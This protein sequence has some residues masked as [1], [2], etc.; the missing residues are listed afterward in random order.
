MGW[1]ERLRPSKE[2]AVTT[3]YTQ[4]NDS[5]PNA[6]SE[7]QPSV[8]Y[9]GE[10]TFNRVKGGN[11]SGAAYQEAAGAPVESNSPLGYHVGW[12]TIIFLN[13]NQMIGTGIFS[14]PGSILNATGS[15]GLALIYW[16]IGAIMA[17]A[18][19]GTYLELASYFPNRSGSQVVYL[20][21]AYPRPKYF[22]PIA[23]AVQSVIL[24]FSSSNAVVLSRY[25]WRIAGKTPTDWE[26]K[27]VAIAA[28]TA[29]VICV[30]V[31]NRY[32]LWTVNVLGAFKVATLIFIS[33]TGFVVL[34]GGV[35]RV[36]QP[37]A[38]FR[39]AFQGTTNNGNDLSTALV[40]IAF[41]YSGYQNAFNVVNEIK[42]PVRTIKKHGLISVAIVSVLY[43]LCNIAYFSAVDKEAFA[44]SKEIAA[45]VFFTQVFGSGAAETVL[46]VLVLLSAYGNLLAVLIGQS[47]MIREIGRQGVL[48][49]TNFWVSTKPFGTPIGPYALKW[50]MTFI[51][52][53]APPAGDAFTFVV[54]LQTYPDSMFVFAMAIG[55]FILRRRRKK[56][57]I[58]RSQFQVWD[59]LL[60]FF[61]LIQV[62]I[63]VMP[64]W[65]PKGG[66]YAGDVS[67]WYATYCVV[68]IGIV[69]LCALY[70]VAWMYVLPKWLGYRI[71]AETVTAENETTATHRLVK[72]PLA[73]V[74]QWDAEHTESG[75]LQRSGTRTESDSAKEQ[76]RQSKQVDL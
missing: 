58:P 33:I 56:N 3:V 68:G 10:L 72:V 46:N 54:S 19:F 69:I 45:A 35:G 32:S 9:D 28:Y 26:M 47:R 57:N 61:T 25:V 1:T 44:Q 13:I 51:M 27:G 14:T 38:N 2:P 5:S 67:F 11:G 21:Q 52:I 34:G 50:A 16:V 39:N 7:D 75:E 40:S 65:P 55:V 71:R 63:L 23:F 30:I 20:E 60:I 49:G 8:I 73:E 22:L 74:A 24:S 42:N 15:V 4:S 37:G 31:H 64:W 41:S 48:P 18:G 59:I 53:V 43:M 12:A 6:S 70:Y 36:P 29:A 62:F 76:E 17:V 66:P